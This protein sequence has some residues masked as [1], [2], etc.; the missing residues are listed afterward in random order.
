MRIKDATA[1]E[2]VI[3]AWETLP[4][5]GNTNGQ[6]IVFVDTRTGKVR[7]IYDYEEFIQQ[8]DIIF[9]LNERNK[10][11]AREKW[12]TETEIYIIGSVPNIYK[13]YKK[14]INKRLQEI[15][16]KYPHLA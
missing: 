3:T 1:F 13:K 16:K 4:E 9:V 6:A 7:T 5:Y 2:V 14:R 8:E 12:Q 10:D 11:E 15:Q